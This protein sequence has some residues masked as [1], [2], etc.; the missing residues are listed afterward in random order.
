MWLN[1]LRGNYFDKTVISHG[2]IM[3][4][5]D[6]KVDFFLAAVVNKLLL[7]YYQLQRGIIVA[8]TLLPCDLYFTTKRYG[9]VFTFMAASVLLVY[10]SVMG[11]KKLDPLGA[12]PE[13]I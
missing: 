12:Q 5:R 11:T 13:N 9:Y 1:V 10:L 8:S 6:V 3:L 7:L 4:K 2:V